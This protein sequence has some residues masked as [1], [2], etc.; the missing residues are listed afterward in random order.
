MG[1]RKMGWRNKGRE[2][3]TE[4]SDRLGETRHR[5][6]KLG[7]EIE[8]QLSKARLRESESHPREVLVQA[9]ASWAEPR[10][11]TNTLSLPE[12]LNKLL[13]SLFC[14]RGAPHEMPPSL[15]SQ[16][17]VITLFQPRANVTTS[18]SYL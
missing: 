8:Q 17:L 15:Y 11:P 2:K 5:E 13:D 4:E 3:E 7:L 18:R 6:G 16:L 9:A 1:L 10:A 14:P 12:G